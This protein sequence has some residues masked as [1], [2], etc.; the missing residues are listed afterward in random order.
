MATRKVNSKSSRSEHLYVFSHEHHHGLIFSVRLKKAAKADSNTLRRYIGDFW[1][2]YLVSHFANEEEAFLHF[3]S[4]AE[5]REQFVSEHKQI[6]ALQNEIEISKGDIV[7]KAIQFGELITQHIRFEE[8]VLFPW[9]QD[10]LSNSELEK[11]G[12]ALNEIEVN[13]HIFDPKFWE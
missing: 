7:E 5:L 6:S 9:L 10:N 3:L 12:L 4:D 13:S 2:N 8:R 11:I 1:K